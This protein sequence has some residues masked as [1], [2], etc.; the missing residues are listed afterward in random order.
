MEKRLLPALLIA[1][2]ATLGVGANACSTA[3]PVTLDEA[4]VRSY[5]DVATETALQGL[6][7]RD[8]EKYTRHAN[9][10]FKAA[11]TQETLDAT[12]AT[13]DQHLGSFESV[14]Y[15]RAEEDDNYVIVHYRATYEKGKAGIRMVFDQDR[16]IAG[17][18]FE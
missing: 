13:I 5:A 15:L 10:Q 1:I 16:L 12:A 4:E 14:E 7:E 2:V 3:A 17:Q 8:L 6:S 9:D 11:V 18:W